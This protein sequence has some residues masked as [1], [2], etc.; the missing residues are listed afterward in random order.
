MLDWDV[1]C[2][3]GCLLLYSDCYELHLN[4]GEAT[5]HLWFLPVARPHLKNRDDARKYSHVKDGTLVWAKGVCGWCGQSHCPTVGG[6]GQPQETCQG[7]S[8]HCELGPCAC[9][10]SYELSSSSGEQQ[11]CSLERPGCGAPLQVCSDQTCP[12]HSRVEPEPTGVWASVSHEEDICAKM[13]A[14][15]F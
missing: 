6:L 13:L 14:W 1:D 10:I 11:G 7:I 12:L 5:P 9:P 8:L 2:L 3:L 4:T 15:G